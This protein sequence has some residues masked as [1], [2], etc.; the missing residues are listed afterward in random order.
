MDI[1]TARTKERIVQSKR[2]RAGSLAIVDLPQVVRTYILQADIVLS[3]SGVSFSCFVSVSMST[4]FFRCCFFLFLFLF[5]VE[6][7]LFRAFSSH[8]YRFFFV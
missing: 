1:V 4:S 2:A 8:Y 5:S 3:S 6:I 7:S